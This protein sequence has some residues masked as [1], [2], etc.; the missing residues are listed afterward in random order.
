MKK[1][2][3]LTR[4][5]NKIESTFLF[6]AIILSIVFLPMILA[7]FVIEVIPFH[8]IPINIMADLF[9]IGWIIFVLFGLFRPA[10]NEM[11]NKA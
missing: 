11:I 8:P 6:F 1:L 7:G 3:I 10:M 9:V 5:N 2:P 4:I